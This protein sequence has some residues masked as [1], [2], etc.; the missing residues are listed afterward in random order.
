MKAGIIMPKK[1]KKFLIVIVCILLVIAAAAGTGALYLNH[2]LN[3]VKRSPLPT[4]KKSLGISSDTEEKYKSVEDKITNIAFFGVDR[5]NKSESGRSDSIII[6]T[7]DSQHNKIKMTS[8]MRDTYVNIEGHGKD[9][10][11]NAYDFGGA[12]LAVKT[13]NQNFNLNIKDYVTVDFFSLWK[14]IDKLGG[15]QI[16]VQP[17]EIQYMNGY[18]KE[19][20]KLNNLTYV[21]QT[22]TGLQT[23][24]G[25][26][27]LAYSRIRYTT[28]GDFVRTERQR[29]VL[30]QLLNKIKGGGTLK[31]ASNI[32][33]LLPYVETSM[34]NMDILSAGTKVMKLGV[35]NIEQER[36][37]IDGYCSGL[38]VGNIW[39]LNVDLDVTG[40]QIDDYIFND[41]KTTPKKPLF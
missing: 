13:L 23:L 32:N 19:L 2:S 33:D 18:L 27:A 38:F 36:F 22:K 12:A 40:K 3:K 10:I 20:T 5:R 31:L 9:K 7:I 35:S 1:K 16:N 39:Y 37:P 6:I 26:H 34:S 41:I 28:G 24:D 29:T 30:M 21:P 17:D 11:T 15:V 25:L 14:I 4:D 8:I